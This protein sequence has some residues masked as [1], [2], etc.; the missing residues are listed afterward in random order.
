MRCRTIALWAVCGLS[1]CDGAEPPPPK[2]PAAVSVVSQEPDI[3]P[4][5]QPATIV[6]LIERDAA[7]FGYF[8][9][10]EFRRGPWYRAITNVIE[11]VPIAR[12]QLKGVVQTC[13]FNPI[14]AL[15]EISLSSRVRE[16]DPDF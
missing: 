16:G 6:D 12:E 7:I 10:E 3:A 15:L 4:E 13:G 5:P 9:A 14:E 1:A 11:P 8:D 2:T